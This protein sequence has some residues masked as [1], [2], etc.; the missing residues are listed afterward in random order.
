M[1]QNIPS[2]VLYTLSKDMGHCPHKKSII[3]T[4]AVAW[5]ACRQSESSL[6]AIRQESSSS[7]SVWEWERRSYIILSSSQYLTGSS[8][9][10]AAVCLNSSHEGGSGW[11]QYSAQCPYY[12]RYIHITLRYWD[13]RWSCSLTPRSLF[14]SWL[15]ARRKIQMPIFC[16]S[17]LV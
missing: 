15:S 2:C 13:R 14:A 10:Q 8:S 16:H 5:L 17:L 12:Y 7:S 11:Y 3:C 1:L 6:L 4:M 9:L